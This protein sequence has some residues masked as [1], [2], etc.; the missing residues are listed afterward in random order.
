M[1]FRSFP[2]A[3]LTHYRWSRAVLLVGFTVGAA[4][5]LLQA[6]RLTL[7]G[8]RESLA[9]AQDNLYSMVRLENPRGNIFDNSGRILATNEKTYTLLFK[10]KV[11]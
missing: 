6:A 3:R 8:H 2:L 7:L 1:E 4:V 10:H 5:I 9:R 11:T